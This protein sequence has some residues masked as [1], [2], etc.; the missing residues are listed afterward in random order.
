MDIA[1]LCISAI[2]FL[3]KDLKHRPQVPAPWAVDCPRRGTGGTVSVGCPVETSIR[4][5]GTFVKN[6][7]VPTKHFY[8]DI[9][10]TMRYH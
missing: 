1:A 6:Y 2:S 7:F 10:T 5:I 3:A 4:H 9:Y 8:L